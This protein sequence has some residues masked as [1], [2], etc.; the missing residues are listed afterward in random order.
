MNH[1][2]L[3]TTTEFRN[4]HPVKQEIIKEVLN[5]H[6]LSS[7]ETILPKMMN[8]N[9]ELSKRNLNFTKDET[10]LLI[11]IMKENMTPAEQKRVDTLMG[12]FYR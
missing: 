2:E 9:K 6:K 3:F 4:L 7:P 5:N 1:Q 8:I 11:N 12:I 10:T